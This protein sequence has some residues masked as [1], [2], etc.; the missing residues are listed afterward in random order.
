[1]SKPSFQ[2]QFIMKV[3]IIVC[4]E[5]LLNTNPPTSHFVPHV[6]LKA[7]ASHE[8]PFYTP[9]SVSDDRRQRVNRMSALTEPRSDEETSNPAASYSKTSAL[10]HNLLSGQCYL[11]GESINWVWLSP[12][13]LSHPPS[14]CLNLFLSRKLIQTNPQTDG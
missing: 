12:C 8:K 7:Q 14:D 10:G 11:P 2:T 6:L 1:M 4:I 9:S 5:Y 13:G 3:V